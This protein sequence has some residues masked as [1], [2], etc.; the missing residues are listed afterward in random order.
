MSDSPLARASLR[1]TLTEQTGKPVSLYDQSFQHQEDAWYGLVR[2]GTEKKLV[3]L[4]ELAD[5]FTSETTLEHNGKPLHLCPQTPANADALRRLFPWTAPVHLD[6][7]SALGCGD[8]LG[9][10]SPG[11]IRAC[12]EANVPPVLA[13]Q[14]IREMERTERTPQGVL[15]DV[16]WAVFEEGYTAG[17]GADA[18]HLKTPED[19]DA[20]F[21]AGYTM[22]TIDPSDYV[23]NEADKLDD[24]ALQERFE[25]L[26]WNRLDTTP[27]EALARYT[28]NPFELSES[29]GS[30]QVEFDPEAVKRSAVKYGAAIAHTNDMARHLARRYREDRPDASYDLEMSVDETDHP[31]RP[32]EHYFVAAELDR[33]GIEVT[34]LAPRFTGHFEKG[35]DFI[36]DLDRFETSFRG[37]ATIAE[38]FGGYKLSIHSGSDKF[39]AFPIIGE[40]AGDHVHLKTAGTSYLEAVRIAARHAPNLFREIVDFA[41]DRFEEDRKTYH[42]STNLDEIPDPSNVSDEALEETYL[43]DDDGRQLLHITYGSVLTACRDGSYRFRDRL[44]QVLNEKEEEHYET[45]KSHFLDHIESVGHMS[46]IEQ[47]KEVIE[48]A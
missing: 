3:V 17:F 34:S 5:P 41:F 39:S 16:S 31:T 48:E 26:P 46:V 8:R 15:D 24:E 28:E 4:G 38:A 29:A 33:L 11:H 10:A 45:L 6:K 37:H 14:S 9:I 12:R 22:Y 40:Y 35:I 30:F 1:Q 47:E 42:V 2:T 7:T 25:A 36:G 21:A 44:Y 27:A 18:D 23:D 19:I 43:E 20:C 13:Q 32:H